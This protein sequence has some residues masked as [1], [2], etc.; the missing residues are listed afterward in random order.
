MAADID[1]GFLRKTGAAL[2]C[3]AVAVCLSSCT[4]S[5]SERE[6]DWMYVRLKKNPATLDPAR[7]VDLDSARIAAKLFNGL[8]SF[9]ED[10]QICADLARSWTLS[11]DG[12]TYRFELRDDAVFFNGRAVTADDVIFSFE[13]VLA[14]QTRSPRTW[15]LARIRG[16]D[17]FMQ[18]RTERIVGL[19]AHGHYTLEIE[20]AEPFAPFLSMLGLTTAY[21]V[22]RE[23]VE[24]LGAEFGRYAGGSGPFMLAEWKHNQHVRLA[25]NPHWRGPA[26]RSSGICYRIIPEDF[27]AMVAFEKGSLDVLPDIMASEYARYTGDPVWRD[28]VQQTPGLNTYYLGLNCSRVPFSDVRVR[29][30][31]NCAIDRQTMLAAILEGRGEAAR[32]PV[33]SLLRRGPAPAGYAYDPQRAR[34]LLA[35][36]GYPDGFSMR[37]Y[38][39]ADSENLDMCQAVQAYLQAVGIRVSIVQLEWS[40]FLAAVADGEADAFWLSWWADYPDAENF[41]YPLF[42]SDNLGAGGNRSRYVDTQFDRLIEQAVTTQDR[43]AREALYARCEY[44]IAEQAPWVFFWHKDTSSIHRPEIC[45]YRTVPL[46]V[47]EKGIFWQRRGETAN[48]RP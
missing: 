7:I 35:E 6:P 48:A 34:V 32:G 13:R 25:K 45:G 26:P 31:L 40:T 11:A 30:A 29:Q 9:D 43:A 41:L 38:Q 20:L 15:V 22:P 28:C 23:E 18:G 17:A 8:V 33:P 21:V 5:F 14:P 19:S 1:R 42:H 36:A 24:R 37:I 10:L 47:M 39:T 27:T 46:T 12:R 2:I 44:L 16:A 4:A 3:A